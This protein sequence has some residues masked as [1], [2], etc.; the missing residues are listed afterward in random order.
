MNK[1]LKEIQ[2]NI[3]KQVRELNKMVQELKIETTKKA[4]RE[5]TLELDNLV[6]RSGATYASITNRI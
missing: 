4:Q 1:S 5:A 2:G 3:N 6:K